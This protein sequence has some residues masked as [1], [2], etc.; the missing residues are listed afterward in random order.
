MIEASILF[1]SAAYTTK[2]MTLVSTCTRGTK[3]TMM[4]PLYADPPACH[5]S[6]VPQ[7]PLQRGMLLSKAIAA[8]GPMHVAVGGDV[9]V[10]STG[11]ERWSLIARG[12][13]RT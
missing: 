7:E 10:V 2:V 4:R 1:P 13:R 11:D 5:L 12:W 8:G 3:E 9:L 6:L